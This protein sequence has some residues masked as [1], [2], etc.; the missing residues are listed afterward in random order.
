MST[1]ELSMAIVW[2]GV[3]IGATTYAACA[4]RENR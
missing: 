3:V 2:A 1:V 4:W